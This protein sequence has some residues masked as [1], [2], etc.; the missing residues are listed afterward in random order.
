MNIQLTTPP[1]KEALSARKFDKFGT[2]T[3]TLCTIKCKA[4]PT[5]AAVA[6]SL[7]GTLA[8]LTH[9]PLAHWGFVALT[10][11]GAYSLLMKEPKNRVT[12]AVGAAA[13]GFPAM[14]TGAF[15]HQIAHTP[16]FSGNNHAMH[17]HDAHNHAAHTDHSSHGNTESGVTTPAQIEI[18]KGDGDILM[19]ISHGAFLFGTLLVLSGHLSRLN[20]FA[21][22]ADKVFG[23]KN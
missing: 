12:Y 17:N 23:K 3:G 5:I 7:S 2:L 6:P 10:A 16:I 21:R 22:I 1:S 19:D 8:S 9:S 20:V 13:I 11:P 15:G 18:P 4:L 14:I